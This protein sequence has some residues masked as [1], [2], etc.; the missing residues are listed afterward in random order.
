MQKPDNGEIVRLVDLLPA[1]IRIVKLVNQI[2]E[3]DSAD[4]FIGLAEGKKEVLPHLKKLVLWG[5]FS[6]Q[7][8]TFDELKGVGIEITGYGWEVV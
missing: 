5:D 1:S 7:Q 4:L 3:G 6:L 8:D 2:Q